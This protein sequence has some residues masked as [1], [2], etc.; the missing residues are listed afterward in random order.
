MQHDVR[1]PGF[2]GSSKIF[3]GSIP[4]DENDAAGI[5]P[6][7]MFGARRIDDVAAGAV[8][9]SFIG[10]YAIQNQDRFQP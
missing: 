9:A 8:V 1:G 4:L 3:T 5:A 7:R 10:L 6:D 2:A